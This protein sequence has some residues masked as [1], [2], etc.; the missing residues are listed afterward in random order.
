[1]AQLETKN[2]NQSIV[3]FILAVALLILINV[4]AN[5]RVAGLPLYGALDL[6]EDGLYTLTDNTVEQMQSLE[7]RVF[8]RVLLKGDLPLE[9]QLLQNKVEELMIDF[10]DLSPGLE[11]EFANP[12]TGGSNK[13]IQ[14]RQRDL[15]ENFG[16]VPVTVFNQQSAAQRSSNAV[17]P[18]AIIYY[19]ERTRVVSFLSLRQP[20]ISDSRRLN[21]AE[22]LLEYNFSRAISSITNN[23]K[24][25]VGFTRGNGELP[26]AQ[27]VDIYRTLA[28]DY[29]PTPVFLDSFATL[30]QDL[31]VLIIAKPTVPFSDF[32]AFKLDQYVMNG[33][34]ILWALDVVGMDYDSLQGRNEF[35]PQPRKLGLDDMFFKYGLRLGP[36]LALDL[37]STPIGIFT[38]TDA[39]G[40]GSKITNI[41]FPYHVKSIPVGEHPIVKNLDPVDLRFPT[42]IESVND[43]PAVKKTVLLQSSNRARRKRLPAPIDLDAQ[44][45]EVDLDRFNEAAL[46][47]AYLME[48]TFTSPYANRLSRAN[49]QSLKDQ[50]IDFKGLSDPTSMIVIADGDIMAN[51]VR[52]DQSYRPLGYNPWDKFIY[53]NKPFML[54]AIEYLINPDGVIAAR[55][56]DVKLRLTDKEAALA[57]STKWRVINIVLPLIILGIFGIIFNFLRR[58][59]Y[60]TQLPLD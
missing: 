35:Y 14:E 8:I 47:F 48:G 54:N 29:E 7:E 18:Y 49:A 60:A 34:K 43:D 25:L 30:P 37:V 56:K 44:K 16:I 12:L 5:S 40:S 55:G 26:G 39:S 13:E 21:Q 17:Y 20:G 3:Q 36:T 9:Y 59:K 51:K 53:A 10:E 2:R 15:Q 41:P 23:D 22:N 6:T 42:V 52:Q 38:G 27:F 4:L 58:R 31:K 50:G 46:P 32:D 19:G 1:M 33:G 11:W 24:P 45:Y 28:E 57:D